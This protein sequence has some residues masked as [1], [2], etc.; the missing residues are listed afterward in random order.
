M[1]RHVLHNDEVQD[2]RVQSLSPGQTG[3]MNGWGVFSTLRVADGVLFAWERHWARM[4]RDAERMRAPFPSEPDYLKSRLLKLVEANNAWN[5]TLRVAVARNRGGAFQGP[6]I[7]RDFDV[8]AFTTDLTDWGKSVRLAIKPQARHAQNEFA[9]TKIMSWA[10]NLAWYEEAHERGFDEVVLLNERG[11]VA[12]CTSANIFMV[13]DGSALTPPLGSGCL[14]GVTRE[15]LLET[16]VNG[17]HRSRADAAAGATRGSGRGFYHLD[18][19]RCFAGA[20]YRG[21]ANRARKPRVRTAAAGTGAI[22]R[23][24]CR[25]LRGI[26][27]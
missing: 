13:Q 19:A 24:L 4:K 8:I 10:Y 25:R 27:P 17:L 20:L 21:A 11:E 15:L 18:D 1:H 26:T 23:G 7:E 6:G 22:S 16:R 5:A 2:A 12:E 3:L 9:G 14:P